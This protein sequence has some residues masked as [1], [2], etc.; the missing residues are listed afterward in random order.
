MTPPLEYQGAP[1]G[2]QEALATG[3]HRMLRMSRADRGDATLESLPRGDGAAAKKSQVLHGLDEETMR[4][5]GPI[6]VYELTLPVPGDAKDLDACSLP[7]GWRY[8]IT[9]KGEVTAEATVVSQPDGSLVLRTISRP[10]NAVATAEAVAALEKYEASG[11][12]RLLECLMPSLCAVWLRSVDAREVLL[13]VATPEAPLKDWDQIQP[14]L[15]DLAAARGVWTPP[16]DS[17]TPTPR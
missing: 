6:P 5:A 7:A 13:P 4:A 11:E 12:L 15:Q 16:G 2:A 9:T 10:G 3:L 17:P 8:L 14:F 1:A